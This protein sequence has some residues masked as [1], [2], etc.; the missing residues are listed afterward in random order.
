M[1]DTPWQGAAALR[2]FLVPL[3]SLTMDPANARRHPKR[4]IEAIR[5]SLRA[6]GQRKPLVVAQGF[7]FAGCGTLQAADLE[8][9][10]EIAVVEASDLSSEQLRAYA[11]ADNQTGDL[12]EWDAEALAKSL[13]PLPEGLKFATGFNPEETK[14][15]VDLA[16][17]KSEARKSEASEFATLKITRDQYVI[18]KGAV[19]KMREQE[20]QPDM[21]E[22][23]ALELLAA[24]YLS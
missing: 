3:R 22:G 23:P 17:S 7:V 18:V 4:N 16:F 6:F 20:G 11:V 10:T 21:S 19:A 14:A 13:G 24:E 12:A 15:I 2:P 5:A 1:V 8:G 9:W